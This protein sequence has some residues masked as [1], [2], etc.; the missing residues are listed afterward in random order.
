MEVFRKYNIDSS[1]MVVYDEHP[2]PY[3]VCL[4]NRAAGTR[5]CIHHRG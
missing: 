3:T 1:A 5:T 2:I 4:L